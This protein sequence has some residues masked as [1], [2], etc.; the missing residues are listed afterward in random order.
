MI[1]LHISDFTDSMLKNGL[2]ITVK[3]NKHIEAVCLTPS[4]HVEV[5]QAQDKTA[6]VRKI[7]ELSRPVIPPTMKQLNKEQTQKRVTPPK[8]V[9]YNLVE[10]VSIPEFS[11][12]YRVV[13]D[14]LEFRYQN[15][16]TCIIE[17]GKV[18]HIM[19]ITDKELNAYMIKNMHSK[20]HQSFKKFFELLKAGMIRV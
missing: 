10:W 15:H 3:M 13:G 19:K 4:V 18:H 5:I 11:F 1:Q 14:S 9:N 16:V 17:V 12:K 7:Q 6:L 2:Q 20:K 8:P